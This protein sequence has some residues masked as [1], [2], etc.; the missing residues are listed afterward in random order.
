MSLIS[1]NIIP[2][3][4]GKT[5]VTNAKEF[6]NLMKIKNAI[7]NIK[8]INGVTVN[9]TTYPVQL[10]ICSEVLTSVKKVEKAVI[11]TGF[12]AIAKSPFNF[13]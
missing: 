9:K 1:E 10:Q 2:G 5:F 12:H 4:S 6:K 7:L 3:N 13:F 11:S 8:G